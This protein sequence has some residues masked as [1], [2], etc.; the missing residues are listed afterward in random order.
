MNK[1]NKFKSYRINGASY[2]AFQPTL[3]FKIKRRYVFNFR[4]TG[5]SYDAHARFG[6][7]FEKVSDTAENGE[8]KLEVH[9]YIIDRKGRPAY[10]IYFRY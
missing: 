3:R 10:E 1:G 6:L 5:Q 7:V 8:T 4:L 2:L 9:T